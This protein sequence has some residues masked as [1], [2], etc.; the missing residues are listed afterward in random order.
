[1]NKLTREKKILLKQLLT[2]SIARLSKF[3]ENLYLMMFKSK[4]TY[5]F[6]FK[7]AFYFIAHWAE[8]QAVLC[9]L[10]V[11]FSV[12]AFTGVEILE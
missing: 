9:T 10:L 8:L 3:V 11:F 5:I 4:Y 12:N 6:F 7:R 2:I 1:M